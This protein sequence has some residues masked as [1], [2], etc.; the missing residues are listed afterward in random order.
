MRFLTNKDE[1]PV[2]LKKLDHTTHLSVCCFQTRS[3]LLLC[4]SG[5]GE[6]S[7][8]APYHCKLRSLNDPQVTQSVHWI[9]Q[10]SSLESSSALCPLAR[11]L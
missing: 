4:D 1:Q 2:A 10:T 7:N 11:L 6:T 3:T 5:S 8:G 9:V